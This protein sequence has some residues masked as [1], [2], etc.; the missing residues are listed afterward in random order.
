MITLKDLLDQSPEIAG[1]AHL[2]LARIFL[3]TESGDSERFEKIGEHRQKADELLP[4]TAQAYFLR[5]MIAISIREK[6]EFLNEALQ[7]DRGHYES[8][9][10]RAFTYYASKKYEQMKEDA[11]VM[12]ALR[13]EDPWVTL[14]V[15][16]RYGNSAIMKRQLRITIMP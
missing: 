10:L 3:E 12:T 9:R 13:S 4:E 11:L 6:L 8:R 7:L 16:L 14:S 1:A 2:L 5:A 15:L